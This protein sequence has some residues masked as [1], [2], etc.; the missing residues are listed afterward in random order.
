M[1]GF[2]PVQGERRRTSRLHLLVDLSS[3]EVSGLLD[4]GDLLSTLL[5]ELDVELLLESHH[6]LNSVEGIS[7]QVNELG[8]SGHLHKAERSRK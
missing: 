1:W 5:V 6:D 7:A 2:I 4:G 8:L 3:N